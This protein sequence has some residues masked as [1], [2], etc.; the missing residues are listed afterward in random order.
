MRRILKAAVIIV[1]TL[2]VV[3]GVLYGLFG[4]RVVLDG[5]ATPDRLEEVVRF[6]VLSGKTWNVPAIAGGYLLVR[7]LAEMAAFDLRVPAR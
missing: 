3:G 1:G 4:L 6:P 2:A 7:N 5:G